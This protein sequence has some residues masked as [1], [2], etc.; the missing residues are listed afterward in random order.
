MKNYL[1]LSCVL[2]FS[3]STESPESPRE[4][5]MGEKMAK[6]ESCDIENICTTIEPE[7]SRNQ[8]GRVSYKGLYWKPGQTIKIKFIDGVSY[9]HDRVKK[10]ASEWTKYANLKFEWVEPNAYAEIKISFK[11]KGNW[12]LVGINSEDTRQNEPSMNFSNL[13]KNYN[14]EEGGE[15]ILHEFGHALGLEHEL[16]HPLKSFQWDIPFV[17]YY[18]DYR[19]KWNK[20]KVDL[21]VINKFS[22]NEVDY[23]AFDK[24]SIMMYSIPSGLILDYIS[25]SRTYKLSQGDKKSIAKIYPKTN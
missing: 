17:Y 4:L 6:M 2:L 5:T 12:S 9:Q 16:Q 18:Y 23:D 21:N 3:C 13:S 19:Y 15:V 1:L 11:G 20:E 7:M 10:Y 22:I 14:E 24:E 8:T 25:F